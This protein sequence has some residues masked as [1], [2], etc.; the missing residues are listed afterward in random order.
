MHDRCPACGLH[1]N[2]EPGYFLGAMYVSYGLGLAVIFVLGAALWA[3]TGWRLDQI[4]ISAVLLFLPF[5]PMLT[6]LSRVLWIYLDQ[7]ID[8]ESL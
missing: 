8:P 2:R 7:K 4:A 5:A 1:F 3:L 6:F